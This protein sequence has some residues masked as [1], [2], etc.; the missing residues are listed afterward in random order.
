LHYVNEAWLELKLKIVSVVCWSSA[1]VLGAWSR[2]ENWRR[3]LSTIASKI[4][5]E[6]P[7][8]WLILIKENCWITTNSTLTLYQIWTKIDMGK[9][10]KAKVT[11]L[12]IS[13]YLLILLCHIAIPR[14][15]CQKCLLI[16]LS[17]TLTKLSSQAWCQKYSVGKFWMP[18]INSEK[19]ILKLSI[20]KHIDKL[21]L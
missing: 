6:L 7:L 8:D 3:V 11:V 2:E 12:S 14:Q 5:V 20:C 1:N 18:L 13:I 19:I 15:R 10:T 17:F 4:G 21:L 16:F 9:P